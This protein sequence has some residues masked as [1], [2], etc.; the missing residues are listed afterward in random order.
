MMACVLTSLARGRVPQ[1]VDPEAAKIALLPE[2]EREVIGLVGAGLKNKHIAERL[3]IT[4]RTVR[5]HL[6]SIFSKLG[7]ADCLELVIY[8]YRYGL[9]TPPAAPALLAA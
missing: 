7:V 5:H 3:S 9:A 2:R 1:A 8:A 6:T 4:E